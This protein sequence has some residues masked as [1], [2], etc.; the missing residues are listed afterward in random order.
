MPIHLPHA[1]PAAPAIAELFSADIALQAIASR[2][3]Q[4]ADFYLGLGDGKP[5]NANGNRSEARYAS[6]ATAALTA[7]DDGG[8]RFIKS[9]ETDGTQTWADLK[10]NGLKL[11]FHQNDSDGNDVLAAWQALA[12]GDLVTAY[13]SATKWIEYKVKT[14][15]AAADPVYEIVLDLHEYDESENTDDL[16]A[17]TEA[18]FYLDT[19]IPGRLFDGDDWLLAEVSRGVAADVPGIVRF[20]AKTLYNASAATA[21]GSISENQA[22]SIDEQGLVGSTGYKNT[23]AAYL[24]GRS[25]ADRLL[26][27]FATRT[28]SREGKSVPFTLSAMG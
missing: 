10:T 6:N 28:S 9:G 12:V 2:V 3:W 23:S 11:Q 18:T 15:V 25:V 13:F 4:E 7:S 21:G 14:A 17:T 27:S 24:L 5:G 16:T 26:V 19:N 1:V 8:Y 20:R 22:V